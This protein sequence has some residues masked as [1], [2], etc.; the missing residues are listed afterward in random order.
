MRVR[1][2]EFLVPRRK[3]EVNESMWLVKFGRPKVRLMMRVGIPLG[4]RIAYGGQ[5]AGSLAIQWAM[6]GAAGLASQGHKIVLFSQWRRMPKDWEVSFVNKMKFIESKGIA[7]PEVIHTYLPSIMGEAPAEVLLKWVGRKT[8]QQPRPFVKAVSKMF[9]K[10]AKPI[11]AG[12]ENLA[13]P[14][15]MLQ[16]RVPIDP[17]YKSLVEAI[18]AAD[19]ESD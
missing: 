3:Y 19:G 14:D 8:R 13:D 17:P 2:P 15:R 5:R 10:S 12:L 1:L 18:R 16:S 4:L 9:G 6:M 11:I 7:F